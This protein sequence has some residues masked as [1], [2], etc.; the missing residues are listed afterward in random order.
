ML[1]RQIISECLAALGFASCPPDGSCLVRG[2]LRATLLDVPRLA[3]AGPHG[4]LYVAL[5]SA[6]HLREQIDALRLPSG[7]DELVLSYAICSPVSR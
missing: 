2:P 7:Q 1:S 6:E 3:I 4:L 5:L